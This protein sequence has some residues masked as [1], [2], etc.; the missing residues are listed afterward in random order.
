[1]K[2]RRKINIKS[3]IS[4]LNKKYGASEL[5]PLLLSYAESVDRK[6]K[7]SYPS[8][9]EKVGN[10]VTPKYMTDPKEIAKKAGSDNGY[11]S[12]SHFYSYAV[13]NTLTA[14]D[15][16]QPTEEALCGAVD[17]LKKLFG[18]E[19]E[20]LYYE[21]SEAEKILSESKYFKN[22]DTETK[23]ECRRQ[24][25][26][27]SRKHSISESEAAHLFLTHDP[28]ERKPTPASRLY[29]PILGIMT[30]VFSL[31]TL[32]VTK[33]PAFFF[34]TLLPMSESAKQLTDYIFSHF[35]RTVPIPK[36]K[37]DFIP[38]NAKTL[39]VITS[40]LSGKESDLELC[41]KLRNCAYANRGKNSNFGLL[42]DLKESEFPSS[43][44]DIEAENRIA[45][46][47]DE[48]N[49]LCGINLILFIRDRRYAPSE[50]KYM[51][52]ERKRGAVIE[53]TRY[54]KGR[55]NGLRVV[56]GDPSV[57]NGTKYVI[58]LDSDTRLYTGAVTDLLGAMLHPS[59][60]P[61]IKNG[62]VIKG[63][64]I[65]QPRMEPSL[66]SADKTPYTVLTAE[67][68]G[69]DIY[70]SASYETYQSIFGEGIFCGKGIFDLDAYSALIDGAF[71]DGSV[72]S[73]DLIEGS[74]LRAGAVTDI[75][76][77][78][79]IPKSPLSCF[80]RSHRWIRG[81]VQA[82]A[83]AGKYVR[84]ENGKLYRN[85][86]SKL[87]AYK[88]YDNVRRAVV[89][90]FAF[91]SLLLCIFRPLHLSP[92][93]SLLALSYLI[94][95]FILTLIS[96]IRHAGR[97]FFSHLI[98]AS[99]S[100]L[101]S[102]IYSLSSL[103]HTALRN[104]DAIARAGYRM[105]FSRKKLLEWKTASESD[106]I[107]GLPL[108]LYSMLPS[109]LIGL[110]L[111]VF[112]P[113]LP[114]RI[115]G[116]LTFLFPFACYLI[117]KPFKSPER[118]PEADEKK[119]R[120][121]ASDTWKYF[122]ER[123]TREENHLPPDNVQLSP[124]ERV[125]HRTSPTNIGLYLISACSASILGIINEKEALSRIKNTLDTVELMPKWNGHLYNWYDTETLFILGQSYISTVDSGNF[126]TSLVTVKELLK[127]HFEESGRRN[128]V[129]EKAEK[130]ISE[131][132]FSYL[133][134]KKKKLM[135][136]GIN[137]EKPE[138]DPPCYDFFT[139]EE[140]TTS[141]YSIARGYVP[142]EHWRYLRRTTKIEN[143]YTVLL[144]WTGTMFEYLMPSLILPTVRGSLSYEALMGAVR[145]QKGTLCQGVWGRSES[146][147]FDFDRDLNYQYKAFGVQSLA[148]K[149]GIDREKVISPYSSF[150]ALS[151]DRSAA[152]FNL[153]RLKKKGMYGEYGF[154][155]ALDMTPERVGS[156][157]AV[158]K[159]YMSHHVGMTLAA[160]TNAC[161]DNVLV[162]AFMSD[163]YCASALELLTEKVPKN[164]VS[165]KKKRLKSAK[166][167]RPEPLTHVFR[168]DKP[169][170]TRVSLVS[171]GGISAAAS[172]DML[173]LSALKGEITIDP[174]V[175]GR[176]YRPRLILSIDNKTTDLMS[177]K[178]RETDSKSISRLYTSRH[179]TAEA[180]LSLLPSIKTFVLTVSA[181]G[182]F[183]TVTPMLVLFPSLSSNS[184]RLSHS[185]YADISVTSEY[186]IDEHALL[187]R[188]QERNEKDG[189][190]CF[191]VSFESKGGGEEFLTKRDHLPEMFGENDIEKLID[192]PFDNET[193]ACIQPL[194]A[195]KKTSNASGKYLLNILITV[196]RS[197][198]EVLFRLSHA[199]KLLKTESGKNGAQIALRLWENRKDGIPPLSKDPRFKPLLTE[200][201]SSILVPRKRTPS[202]SY[203]VTDFYKHGISG[204]DPIMCLILE[205]EIKPHSPSLRWL[206]L[207]VL[208]H[209]HLSLCGI[210]LDTVILYDGG[211]EYMSE[212][213]N[214]IVD[215]INSCACGF[216]LKG[217]IY[218][219]D[220]YGDRDLFENT[221]SVSAVLDGS[222]TLES[223][224]SRNKCEITPQTQPITHISRSE[225]T[226]P[227]NALP[228]YGGFFTENGFTLNK[229]VRGDK[230]LPHSYVYALNHFGTLVTDCSLGYTWI[231]NSHER[232]ITPFLPDN[233]RHMDG[234]RLIATISDAEY[235]LI[236]CSHTV[237]FNRDCTVW[238]GKAGPISYTVTAAI[239]PKLPCKAV[240]VT[241]FG[242]RDIK[243]EYRV[244]PILGDIERRNRPIRAEKNDPLTLYIPT[245]T[246][247]CSDTAFVLKKEYPG[248]VCFLLGAFPSGRTKVLDAIMKKYSSRDSFFACAEEYE[249]AVEALLPN[250]SVSMPDRYLSLMT[251][252][253][254]PYQTLVC[255]FYGRTGFYQSGGAYG[256]RDQLQDCLAIM[257][258]AP[259]VARTHILRCACRQY[260]EGDVN[261]W[262]HVVKGVCRGVRTR[263]RDDLL[264]LPYVASKYAAFTGDYGI[265]DIELPY[266]VSPPLGE[267]ERDRYE[268]P[269]KSKYRSS[270][271]IHCVKAIE[272]SLEFGSHG[273]PLMGGGDWN[274]G[275]NEVGRNGGESVWLGMFL[276]LVLDSFAPI[277]FRMGDISGASKYRRIRNELTAAVEKCFDSEK[278]LRAF[279][280]DGKEV[281]GDGFIDVLPQ[282]FSVF[283]KCDEKRSKTALKTAFKR[284]FSPENGTFLLLSPPFSRPSERDVGYI[285]SYP[286]GIRENGG[287]YTHA[288]AWA[289]MAMAEA[290]MQEM[291]AEVLTA[292]NPASICRTREGAERYRGEPYFV[293]GDVSGA[294]DTLGRC[295]W[296]LYTGSAGW[297]FNALFAAVLGIVIEG[298][299]F[300]VNPALSSRLPYF[301]AVF[302]H[303]GT[304]YEISAHRGEKNRC[305]LDGKNVNNLFHFDKNCHLLEITV[306]ISDDME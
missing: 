303:L 52:W 194:C 225:S 278:Y 268:R 76:L 51:G 29:F 270:L 300:I 48:I 213:K 110:S 159:S 101:L 156:G 106:G 297:L 187:Y 164:A 36:K 54:L 168:Y 173:R 252:Y 235:D 265:F 237:S 263:Y 179:F 301:S 267:N 39:T 251:E 231:G 66:L 259:K 117:G 160:I 34:F 129:I 226:V 145:E 170:E 18:I 208:C 124:D 63:H 41:D 75:S 290:G 112:C 192:K 81:D 109:M 70:A 17:Y 260:E 60:T 195:V 40:L 19:T 175:F 228:V 190:K 151:F 72:L 296:S 285:S 65:L 97:R 118:I 141:F 78:D 234:E 177:G 293:A 264:W 283:A 199:R 114:L 121:Y 89:P 183:R 116:A 9:F 130:I 5:F 245:V 133:Y 216:F 158:I 204:D 35:V 24:V 214:A 255:R 248:S 120:E 7:I 209:K 287:Q 217:G 122:S 238:S 127:Q 227:E 241:Y 275:M 12:L 262:W 292:I 256:F 180:S 1:M 212:K 23:N 286:Y 135:L 49:R 184:D 299:T 211:G 31:L 84:N 37:L 42:C 94:I 202:G 86:I 108:V 291:A 95:P 10:T 30:A 215:T 82:L 14:L 20:E 140:R 230:K 132:D 219:I 22:C 131:T 126:I 123:V 88:I 58:T 73:H 104:A 166:E 193:G 13:I 284:L 125:A 93:I 99:L 257:L 6:G 197:K 152:L 273:L 67:N 178:P 304:T 46:K 92:Y 258:S 59:N 280:S 155:E 239:D 205:S 222:F 38:D 254:L 253:Y 8:F 26:I 83:F 74:R 150:L 249:K 2:N 247:D 207:F 196:G 261:H 134:D 203:N 96:T 15:K 277:S 80:D 144:S 136:I 45:D 77:T 186:C 200:I 165:I 16:A 71:P 289:V 233:R 119:L 111:L 232:R 87:S 43:R 149:N 223:F 90:I 147:Y 154:Y 55:D 206:E 128:E 244:R 221:A 28:F 240:T 185:T 163:P 181:E 172:G 198:S 85:P 11:K 288:A 282:A 53:L 269:S 271:Y 21:L 137:P 27:A 210:K 105:L 218:L 281:G 115:L 138:N 146:G 57:L 79:D 189:E 250:L 306:E 56:S 148:L 44:N 201:L 295:G 224:I 33:N 69:S 298:D 191:A 279:Y 100:A 274:D 305:L 153:S 182:R 266:I 32:Y 171:D 113:R 107:K 242:G 167:L 3:L 143:G 157:Y 62:R 169:S 64:A 176:I 162:N 229:S 220:G 243:T 272:R 47:I 302:T 4:S 50:G 142:R 25:V 174:F 91:F 236:A 98:P 68:G 102:L 188:K 246:A 276:S 103:T 139:S 161:L 61:V 294:P